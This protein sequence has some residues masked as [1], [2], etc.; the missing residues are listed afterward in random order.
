MSNFI[1]N[2]FQFPTRIVD[3]ELSNLTEKELKALLLYR[4]HHCTPT[5]EILNSFGFT[6]NE[7]NECLIKYGIMSDDI[8]KILIE[9]M[10]EE[11][12]DAISHLWHWGDG[13][14]GWLLETLAGELGLD[15]PFNTRSKSSFSKKKR[16]SNSLRKRVFERDKYRCISCGTHLDLTCDHIFPESKGGETTLENLQTMCRSCNSQKGTKVV[17]DEI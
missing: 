7:F 5:K 4:R 1:V 3:E 11:Y 14:G 12:G 8:A 15:T 9:R 13:F 16:I 6:E 17:T 2:S 10:I